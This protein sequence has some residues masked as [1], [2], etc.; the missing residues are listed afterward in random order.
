MGSGG[1]AR[2]LAE[3]SVEEGAAE[4][5]GARRAG[6]AWGV[7]LPALATLPAI[8]ATVR[9]VQVGW[10]PIADEGIIA[11][12]AHDVLTA[13]TPALGQ[14]SLASASAGAPTRSPGPLGY[15][16]LS[17]AAQIGPLWLIAALAGVL[18]AVGL[19]AAA[20][21]A[22]RRGGVAL[23]VAVTAGLVLSA[24]GFDPV[25]LATGWN[26][27]IGLVPM[28]LLVLLAWSVGVGDRGRFP[29]LVVVA[30]FVTQ[31]HAAHLLPT[32][33]AVAVALVGGWGP[34]TARWWRA[35]R[36]RD[37]DPDP[38]SGTVAGR[39]WR[40]L[41]VGVVAGL[42]LWAPPLAQQLFGGRGN[43]SLLARSAGGETQGMAFAAKA[44]AGM[45]GVPPAFTRGPTGGLALVAQLDPAWWSPEVVST[46]V[47]VVALAVLVG[48]GVR[49]RD[50]EIAVP[51]LLALAALAGAV[52]TLRATPT[53]VRAFSV[54]YTTWWLIPVGM[55]AWVVVV[56]AALRSGPRI[57]DRARRLATTRPGLVGLAPAVVAVGTVAVALGSPIHDPEAHLYPVAGEVGDAVVA[58]IRPGRRYQ[59]LEH[60][61]LG[62]QLAPGLAYRIRRAGADPVIVGFD[63][64]SA[65][66]AYVQD[67]SRCAAVVGFEPVEPGRPVPTVPPGTE[68]L[69]VVPVPPGPVVTADRVAVTWA[70]DDG[71]PSC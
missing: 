50:R 4:P 44:L 57:G 60:G 2:T 39:S 58:E 68:I 26:P 23:M 71:E 33:G 12:R 46:V 22:N 27:S 3:V 5:W 16:V 17:P 62:L 53:G 48:V 69:R 13:R 7:V 32:L 65:G 18:A 40:P 6:R 10:A 19:A 9:V 54:A 35:R 56:A 55:L 28:A 70:P 47:L 30:A 34:D 59:V 38:D 64:T 51:P 37:P 67:G 24:R 29:A 66:P 25:N 49:R 52:V 11:L 61:P 20:H 31:I 21:E 63:G 14:L 45:V 1:G 42:V 36:R 15:W 41:V 43:L 8:R